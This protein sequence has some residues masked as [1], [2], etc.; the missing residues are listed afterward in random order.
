MKLVIDSN[1]IFSA[2]IRDSKARRLIFSPVLEL[3][4]PEFTLDEIKK[5]ES[6]IC[7][8]GNLT[9]LEFQLLLVLLF[10]KI[11]LIPNEGYEDKISEAQGLIKDI[12]DVAFLALALAT[13]SA[14]IWSEDKGFNEQGKV[15]S[16]TTT[17][18][19]KLYEY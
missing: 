6:L 18:L 19:L 11:T 5:Y 14:G 8:K 12:D 9:S 1:I 10:E 17:E 15:R 7:E 3:L 4:T 13:K 16:W 2:F